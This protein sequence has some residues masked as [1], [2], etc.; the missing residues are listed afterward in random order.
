MSEAQRS[1]N[2]TGSAQDPTTWDVETFR[3]NVAAFLE[4]A[5][6]ETGT[7]L[8]LTRVRHQVEQDPTFQDVVRQWSG[9]SGAQRL[10]A[11]K[12]IPEMVER[13][14]R[15]VLPTCVQCGECCRRGSPTL[16]LD[17]LELLQSGAI[18][19]RL[20]VTLRRG[21][22]VRSAFEDKP[23]ILVDERIK[24][25]EKPGT[26]ECVLFDETTHQ[27]AVYAN[28][29]IQCRAQACWDPEQARLL[30]NE[31]YLAR[32]DIFKG[33][34]LLLDLMAE[35]D[36]RCA[37]DR[38]NA[39]FMRLAQG[40]DHTLD[41][42]LQMVAFEDHFRAFFAEQ[43]KIPGDHLD[44]VFGRSFVDLAPLFGFRVRTEEDGAR[45]LVQEA[46]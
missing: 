2:R 44:L 40:E 29:P 19:W 43:L 10:D 22:P 42:V 17:D 18:P 11:W 1:P 21:E 4:D 8:P 34:E 32:R 31:L 46:E 39:A 36:R 9:W 16:M 12:K 24:L 33:V 23:A 45:C 3:G 20:L 14:I 6:R 15:E 5:V 25:R 13:A 28:R 26:R 41:E 7:I 27:C 38:L 35:H 37:F 30:E